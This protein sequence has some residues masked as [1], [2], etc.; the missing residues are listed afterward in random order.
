MKSIFMK[1][2]YCIFSLVLLF[3]LSSFAAVTEGVDYDANGGCSFSIK[4][5]N[6]LMNIGEIPV[7]ECATPTY[8]L[9]NDI[10]VSPAKQTTGCSS[11]WNFANAIFKG[12][13]DG[14]GYKISGVCLNEEDVSNLYLFDV[15]NGATF[16]NVTFENIYMSAIDKSY[17]SD[18]YLSLLKTS[19]DYDI[20]DNISIVSVNVKDVTIEGNFTSSKVY[21]GLFTSYGYNALSINHVITENVSIIIDTDAEAD[22]GTF[23]GRTYAKNLSMNADTVS[24]SLLIDGDN[25]YRYV[26]GLVGYVGYADYFSASQNLV[27]T[28]INTTTRGYTNCVGGFLGYASVYSSFSFNTSSYEGLI[29]AY[30]DNGYDYL[31]G[32]IGSLSLSGSSNT[33]ADVSVKNPLG[34]MGTIINSTKGGYYM[35][36]LIG[37]LSGKLSIYNSD[38]I[39]TISAPWATSSSYAYAAGLVGST[40]SDLTVGNCRFIGNLPAANYVYGIAYNNSTTSNFYDSYFIDFAENIKD[41]SSH[42]EKSIYHNVGFGTTIDKSATAYINENTIV[43]A[44]PNTPA[45]AHAVS[46]AMGEDGLPRLRD[47]Y[48]AAVKRIL[49]TYS[50]DTL[51]D[52]YTKGDGLIAYKADGSAFTS[53][54]LAAIEWPSDWPA[55]WKP[56]LSK[57]YVS[58]EIHSIPSVK[59][60]DFVVDGCDVSIKTANGLKN[61]GS[62]FV[63][64]CSNLSYTLANDIV[65]EEG[66]QNS[67]CM[68]NWELGNKNINGNFDGKG[69]TISGICFKTKNSSLGFL[70]VLSQFATIKNVNFSNIYLNVESSDSYETNASLFYIPQDY[71]ENKTMFFEN[72]NLSS[73]SVHTTNSNASTNAGIFGGS[74][75]TNVSLKDITMNGSDVRSSGKVSTAGSLFGN[76]LSGE[77]NVKNVK[78]D[79]GYAGAGKS[80][81]TY[82]GGFVGFAGPNV[83]SLNVEG[84]SFTY[85]SVSNIVCNAATSA[86]DSL[87]AG[88][89]VGKLETSAIFKD[90]Y[91]NSSISSY[92]TS[93][94]ISAVYSGG[95]VGHFHGVGLNSVSDSV[96]GSFY[97][98]TL[99]TSAFVHV[100][101]VVGGLDVTGPDSIVVKDFSMNAKMRMES[102]SY[103]SS[104]YRYQNAYFGGVFGRVS[105]NS[106]KLNIDGAAISSK[107]LYADTLISISPYSTPSYTYIGGLIGYQKAKTEISNSYVLGKLLMKS[108]GTRYIS[109]AVAYVDGS[110]NV[111]KFAYI[112]SMSAATS[113]YLQGIMRSSAS[114]GSSVGNS[115]AIDLSGLMT[116]LWNYSS[117][118][119]MIGVGSSLSGTLSFKTSGTTKGSYSPKSFELAKILGYNYDIDRDYILPPANGLKPNYH[120]YA[121]SEGIIVYDVYTDGNGFISYKPDGSKFTAADML[122]IEYPKGWNNEYKINFT[123]VYSEDVIRYVDVTDDDIKTI[124]SE[125]RVLVKS[126]K[127][128]RVIGRYKF[129][130]CDSITY[131]LTKDIVVDDKTQAESCVTNWNNKEAA[132]NGTLDGKGYTVSGICINATDKDEVFVFDA[133]AGAT[134]KDIKFEN[135]Y[136]NND[137]SA[138]DE[139]FKVSL[140]KSSGEKTINVENVDLNRVTVQ[141]SNS[142]SNGHASLLFAYLANKLNISHVKV[143]NSTIKT[144][145]NNMAGAL[146]GEMTNTADIDSSDVA[147]TFNL[148]NVQ[149]A[150]GLVG[151]I[152]SAFGGSFKL[153]NSS[154]VGTVSANSGV[155]I[156]GV[157][158][159]IS[160][161]V[162]ITLENV[163]AISP[164]GYSGKLI[165]VAEDADALGGLVGTAHGISIVKGFVKGSISKNATLSSSCTGGLLGCF[166]G[167]FNARNSFFVG[168]LPTNTSDNNKPYG[169][170][171]STASTSGTLTS[172]YSIDLNSNASAL[173]N[174]SNVGVEKSAMVNVDEISSGATVY[175][176][177]ETLT[178]VAL[179]KPA[180]AYMLGMAH[181]PSLNEGLPI[182]YSTGVFVTHKVTWNSTKGLPLLVAY[183]NSQGKI[184]FKA[185][186]SPLTEKDIPE[187]LT[188]PVDFDKYYSEDAFYGVEKPYDE[189]LY[190]VVE[191]CVTLVKTVAAFTDVQN[192]PVIAS[193][194]KPIF[195]LTQ[196]MDFNAEAIAGC[197][198]NWPSTGLV[199]PNGSILDGNGHSISGICVDNGD[200]DAYVF[201]TPYTSGAFSQGGVSM[202]NLTIE[203]V[204]VKAEGTTSTVYASLFRHLRAEH[205]VNSSWENVSVKN[206]TIDANGSDS[207]DLY[208][209]TLSAYVMSPYIRNVSAENVTLNVNGG[210]NTFV[211][212]L[213]GN[214]YIYGGATLE[215]VSF[216]GNINVEAHSTFNGAKVGGLMGEATYSRLKSTNV[217]IEASIGLNLTSPSSS[218][219]GVIGEA[220][221]FDGE[222]STFK[223]VFSGTVAS[224]SIGGIEGR[225]STHIYNSQHINNSTVIGTGIDG[226]LFDLDLDAGNVG[227]ILGYA[228]GVSAHTS[229][230][231]V[232]GVFDIRSTNAYVGGFVGS[233]GS[234]GGSVKQSILFASFAS[235]PNNDPFAHGENRQFTVSNSYAV[236]SGVEA[237][238]CEGYYCRFGALVNEAKNSAHVYHQECDTEECNTSTVFIDTVA[239]KTPALTYLLNS[240]L[241]NSIENAQMAPKVLRAPPI[242]KAPDPVSYEGF[243]YDPNE[244]DGYPSII[245]NGELPTYRVTWQI[246]GMPASIAYTDKF[247]QLAYAADG[248]SLFDEVG[249]PV[250]GNEIP[251]KTLT[252]KKTSEDE[253]D[254]IITW[255]N[256]KNENLLWDESRS[257]AQDVVYVRMAAPA[258]HETE[259]TVTLGDVSKYKP[260]FQPQEIPSKFTVAEALALPEVGAMGLCQTGWDIYRDGDLYTSIT[261][262]VNGEYLWVSAVGF[263]GDIVVMPTFEAG[264]CATRSVTVS[265]VEDHDGAAV[266]DLVK[267][268]VKYG[269][270]VLP[271]NNG[272]VT[273]PYVKGLSLDYEITALDDSTFKLVGVALN[274]AP[275]KSVGSIMLEDDVVFGVSLKGISDNPGDDDPGDVPPEDPSDNPGDDPDLPP[276]NDD[277]YS[278]AKVDFVNL[279]SAAHLEVSVADVKAKE[280]V[281]LYA[282][283]Y[284]DSVW[285]KDTLMTANA[286]S[287]TYAMNFFPL[288]PDKKYYVEV[289]L[290]GA[291]KPVTRESREV[292]VS[293]VAK[294]VESGYWYMLSM[295]GVA[296]SYKFPDYN[297]AAFYSW[298]E[299]FPIGEYMQYQRLTSLKDVDAASGYWIYTSE[300][301]VLVPTTAESVEDSIR[302]N[303]KNH[304]TGWNLVAN[305]YSW[306]LK[307]GE[308]NFEDP[309]DST[310]V[311]WKWDTKNQRYVI[312]NTLDVYEAMWVYTE[313]NREMALSSEPYFADS[314]SY[315]GKKVAKKASRDSWSLRLN[316]EGENGMADSW[317]VIGLGRHDISLMKPP[318]AVGEALTL[319]IKDGNR[320]LA[321]SIKSNADMSWNIELASSIPQ[322]AKLS[323]AGLN[324]LE[325][326]GLKAYL[327]MDGSVVQLS[328]TEPLDIRLG[329][330]TRRAMLKVSSVPVVAMSKG[331]SELRYS[332]KGEN[333]TV[334]FLLAEASAKPSIV[335]LYDAQG[336]VLLQK[337]EESY[338]G[339]HEVSLHGVRHSGIGIL[340]VSAGGKTQTA[341]LKF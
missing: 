99:S 170:A 303:L 60:M 40:Y 178:D 92:S 202:K 123:Q 277:H 188:D 249:E 139:T 91:V 90:N 336:H 152:P 189:N 97:P 296:E 134:I 172:C 57:V 320:A 283:L 251:L 100:G 21:S 221:L 203:N 115:Y 302:W 282:S 31:G 310:Q 52:V 78:I 295:A 261:D 81:N 19:N 240:T 247:G 264:N 266:S 28:S 184:A 324:D 149:Y 164:T 161:K 118:T 321:K 45:F 195:Q 141:G 300:P 217:S 105:G 153:S 326:L 281:V 13:L 121:E 267:F 80:S 59:G 338:A 272:K 236:A 146:V 212:G 219:G 85:P 50:S 242:M 315:V 241:N 8:K 187:G 297:D 93:S 223:G 158:G 47:S 269:N 14:Q 126:P 15:S 284:A 76:V 274:K 335:T 191:G 279:G 253:L 116:S 268:I 144:T 318:V 66:N 246:D 54:D 165:D 42:S 55:E 290:R 35:G 43:S 89:L 68:T 288:S 67:S 275:V 273:V 299:D 337:R 224:A 327:E 182:P 51:Y 285:I 192:A 84:S 309:E 235:G 159:G 180:F 114:T 244:N 305:P 173:W 27:K 293:A 232:Q 46:M 225:I 265:L 138:D 16:A 311:P 333:L 86:S 248:S 150:G 254:S 63:D 194:E 215:D 255:V 166:T 233:V 2:V 75:K 308:F 328:S 135:I 44:N 280:P 245:S 77:V 313:D 71:V 64:E 227:G 58:D 237:M 256:V 201:D 143:E 147:C 30:G 317:N 323:V 70:F 12:N 23:I 103:S 72:I 48:N 198:S 41:V 243:Y 69:H 131:E 65:I 87:F 26:G 38:V 95:L 56:S 62:I 110:A 124:E 271:V 36:G 1:K 73:V 98:G 331:I 145:G 175:A 117:N 216:N 136:L 34:S 231:V 74:V 234:S 332:V 108:V 250:D 252:K 183:T 113:G 120:V 238:D 11:N 292:E 206:V 101:G 229:H 197:T 160:S 176:N 314:A 278:I 208:A 341:K 306:A 226:K 209:G 24:S 151:F 181:E 200:A 185:D 270:E 291:G 319:E 162:Y 142:A 53:T 322:V 257:F 37:Y 79:K 163:N 214:G 307:V 325:Q 104:R 204:Y 5:A 211:G 168:N 3:A 260:F 258:P 49:G 157:L 140:F 286:E 298:N 230:N 276:A 122:A 109:G 339:L 329:A 94:A 22:V 133:S 127:G 210:D 289:L 17:I 6:G 207:Y 33:I 222:K 4:T 312:A 111:D 148:G 61:I 294:T 334:S 179:Q 186:G 218:V 205:G 10:V 137:R 128:L 301:L 177:D 190:E 154:F 83:I 106:V 171:K 259:F 82:V 132:I 88:G 29:T 102:G 262:K 213:I 7:E 107:E 39:G 169:L 199:I 112:G 196:D 174:R 96:D 340:K 129:S 316:L 228:R 193:C 9:A 239:P 220:E 125:C 119:Q 167:S 130:L 304:Y 20:V 25:G 330:A 155:G 287:R 18:Y 263:S 32:L 156:G